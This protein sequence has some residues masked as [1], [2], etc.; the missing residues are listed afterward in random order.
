[1]VTFS[2]EGERAAHPHIKMGAFD[3]LSRWL[4]TP[5]WFYGVTREG[6]LVMHYDWPGQLSL[7][8][9]CLSRTQK[10]DWGHWGP[11]PQAHCV[12][13]LLDWVLLPWL[14]VCSLCVVWFSCGGFLWLSSQRMSQRNGRWVI[15]YTRVC[16]VAYVVCISFSLHSLSGVR[17]WALFCWVIYWA[18]LG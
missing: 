11:P 9:S 3:W 13:V 5:S 10:L 4:Q 2:C 8:S 12:C 7:K 18:R 1:M 6:R 14:T 17:W 15:V 16:V